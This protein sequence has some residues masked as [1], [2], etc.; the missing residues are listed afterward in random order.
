MVWTL[1][2]FL[3]GESTNLCSHNCIFGKVVNL[4]AAKNPRNMRILCTREGRKEG[5]EPP[6]VYGGDW[7]ERRETSENL[8]GV[9][10]GGGGALRGRLQADCT[11]LH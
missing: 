7:T 6:T 11:L 5:V 10:G 4:I 8:H 1:Q 9:R 3:A 2:A